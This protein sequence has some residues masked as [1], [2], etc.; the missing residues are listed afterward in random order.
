MELIKARV[1][2]KRKIIRKQGEV[3]F[4]GNRQSALYSRKQG[5][6]NEMYS[7]VSSG[8]AHNIVHLHLI[9]CDFLCCKKKSR[10]HGGIL[11]FQKGNA[12]YIE[13]Y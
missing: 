12:I 9:I 6:Y 5:I 7:I 4:Q 8:Q 11:K 3:E 10:S 2:P 13:I 1:K